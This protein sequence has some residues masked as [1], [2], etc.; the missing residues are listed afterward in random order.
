MRVGQLLALQAICLLAVA[1]AA[2]TPVDQPLAE[3][4]GESARLEPDSAGSSPAPPRSDAGEME[5]MPPRP[6]GAGAG[7]SA[8]RPNDGQP[9]APETEPPQEFLPDNPNSCTD[10]IISPERR[11]LDMYI[12]MDSN[13]TL[14]GIGL[15]ELV[16][17][18]LNMFVESS[19]PSATGVGIRY[20]GLE[21]DPAAY[22]EADVD[23]ELLSENAAAISRSTA[24]RRF[25]ASPM[26]P[27]LQGG[28]NYARARAIE[29]PDWKQ[30]VVLVSD[31]FTQDFM[32]P[33]TPD[34][35]Q[36][37][38]ADGYFGLPAVETHV[39]GV[40]AR[41]NVEGLDEFV[42]RFGAFNDIARA[43]GSEVSTQVE[44]TD[45]PAAFME[46][47]LSVRRRAQ[48]CEFRAPEGV[49]IDQFGVWR[50]SLAD[51]VPRVANAERCRDA[52]GWYYDRRAA[53]FAV[54]LCP[55]TCGWLRESDEHELRYLLGCA[56]TTRN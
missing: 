22:E 10:G 30:V 7:G 31:G 15:W 56:A 42:A 26:L 9:A 46:A 40:G 19:I 12:L 17:S 36:A 39:V 49:P 32:C 1:I 33:Y 25:T 48:P 53:P 16:T 21:C 52:Q 24:L 11:R 13:I 43:G 34:D 5:P 28:I 38:A 50:Y 41:V 6:A 4:I 18:G 23:V 45:D 51:E 29:Y 2:C 20:F 44:R 8:A 54:S 37:A 55:Q 27:A 47:L 14:P 35:L 3:L